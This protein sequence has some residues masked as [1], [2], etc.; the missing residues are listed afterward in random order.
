[1]WWIAN[2]YL[3]PHIRESKTVWDSG[4]HAV[5]SRYQYPFPV[6]FSKSWILDWEEEGFRILWAVFRIPKPKIP[7]AKSKI[8]CA[9]RFHRQKF[10]W[11]RYLIWGEN[12]ARKNALGRAVRFWC[13]S[14]A[15]FSCLEITRSFHKNFVER[16]V[17]MV[18]YIGGILSEKIDS[19]KLKKKNSHTIEKIITKLLFFVLQNSNKPSAHIEAVSRGE[20]TYQANHRMCVLYLPLHR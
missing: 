5:D 19:C 9:S 14:N 3:S 7:E 18:P 20:L 8:F 13:E 17:N 4:F 16:A 6:F 11:F 15:N 2:A 10:H 12:H 1:M